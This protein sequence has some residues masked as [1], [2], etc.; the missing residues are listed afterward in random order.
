MEMRDSMKVVADKNRI[1]KYE[2]DIK[3]TLHIQLLLV[4]FHPS[5]QI[6]VTHGAFL[7]GSQ[8]KGQNDI[9]GP[10]VFVLLQ[11]T[12]TQLRAII[13]L[14]GSLIKPKQLNKLHTRSIATQDS[15]N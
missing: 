5:L 4:G 3:C 10:A 7:L 13:Y 15:G 1:F 11:P 6:A 8:G 14:L 9:P 12:A 2:P